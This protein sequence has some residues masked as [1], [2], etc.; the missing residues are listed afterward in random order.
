MKKHNGKK[1]I[2]VLII[3][4]VLAVLAFCFFRFMDNGKKEYAT[5]TVQRSDISSSVI[6]KGTVR[7]RDVRNVY[8]DSPNKILNILVKIGDEVKKG[9]TLATLDVEK[10]KQQYDAAC[11]DYESAKKNYDNMSALSES[12]SVPAF[13][14][15]EA[16]SAL[17][18]AE[19]L[20]RS[21][22]IE[23]AGEIIS[24]I[25]GI[26]TEINC[27]EGGYASL[28]VLQQPAFVIEDQS[29][30]ILKADAKEKHISSIYVGQAAEITSEAMGNMTA[31]G[32]VTEIAPSGKADL[33]TG[34][35]VIPVTVEFDALREKWMTGITG[36]AALVLTANDALTVPINAVSE[37]GDETRVYVLNKDKNIRKVAV[38]TGIKDESRIQILSGE[39]EEGDTVILNPD[40]YLQSNN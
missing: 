6:I 26:V 28:S 3:L 8:S 1:T 34:S 14:L 30:Y 20:C 15:E 32:E 19:L 39:L 2:V 37:N 17:N 21:Y 38:E 13:S 35:V 24:P 11:I 31:F 12:G 36:K 10:L 18:K 33:K 5:D 25:D 40:A 29:G 27:S 16:K 9:Q 7:G 4:L 23:N 22:D